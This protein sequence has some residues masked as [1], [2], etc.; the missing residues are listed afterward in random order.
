[1]SGLTRLALALTAGWIIG[2]A[3]AWGIMGFNMMNMKLA[4]GLNITAFVPAIAW[5]CAI[6][7]GMGKK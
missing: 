2:G 4:L 6:I 7:E 1:M 5:A 3:V